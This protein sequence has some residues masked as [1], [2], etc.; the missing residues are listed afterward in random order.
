VP[1]VHRPLVVLRATDEE[2]GKA[3]TVVDEKPAEAA[4]AASNGSG[5]GAPAN[6]NG[7]GTAAPAT[8]AINPSD[9]E[10][11][12]SEPSGGDKFWTS[13]K[14]AFALPWRRFKKGSVLA[15]KLE[16]EISDQS[17]G[18]L[19]PGTSIP[20]LCEALHKAALDPRVTGLAIEVAPLALGY[21]K[22][23]EIRRYITLFRQSG[24]FTVAFMKQGGEKEY[25][26][27]SAC[28]E[29]YA[30]PT[31]SLS[32]RGF[33][34]GGTFL[35]GVLDKVGVEPQV[36]RIG[37][38]KSAGDQ[39]LRR[40]MAAEQREQLQCILDDTYADWVA[41]VAAARGKSEQEVRDLLDAGVYDTAQLAQGGWLDGL[42]YEDELI[43][44]LKQ[45][46]APGDKPEKPLRR[47]ALRKYQA[48]SPTAFG[49]RKGKKRV[50]VLRTA[51]AI[52][53]KA[54]SASSASITPDSLIPKLRA[55]A[56]DKSVA[57]V[58]LRVDSPGG[59]ALASDLMWR[60]VKKLAEKK[61]VIA[62]MA[63]VA[64][65]GGYYI[66]MAC[67]KIVAEPLTVTGSIGVVTGKFNLG[68]L[69]AKVGYTKE[70]ISRGRFAELLADNRAFNSEEARL[71]EEAARHAYESFRN[72]A[73]E[74][75]GMSVDAMQEVA[76]GRVWTGK[77]ALQIGLV[78]ALGGVHAA[79][80]LAKQA[81][82]L[83]ADEKV[84]VVEVGRARSSPLA[85]LQGGA[86]ASLLGAQA[87]GAPAASPAALLGL[88]LAPLLA[89]SPS[90]S[91]TA[92]S[93]VSAVLGAQ[94][95]TAVASSLGATAATAAA[96]A[97]SVG[98][99]S[100]PFGVT[101]AAE[102]ESIV[103]T[104]AGSAAAVTAAGVTAGAASSC[105]SFLDE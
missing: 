50:V 5:N 21:A 71:F 97:V 35:R 44:D 28:Q 96:E 9:L 54:T 89:A 66:A 20:Q 100:S 94:L 25:Y 3:V 92:S 48:V 7:N 32:L 76:Q 41:T 70:L 93:L 73:A 65:S 74:S 104:A 38:Y 105:D 2:S 68:E 11:T 39:L 58:V 64:A 75:R 27:A 37:A 42:K 85:L 29:I 46:T 13:F 82:G 103:V 16:G 87:S 59:D 62:S 23:Q 30:P 84:A 24:K 19:D 14:L 8:L 80:T 86:I 77:Q 34:V 43:D 1:V 101:L 57:A 10:L 79:V 15:I 55:L 6:G 51:G 61:P 67:S 99:L 26:L 81:A 22:L 69:Y 56:K 102:P 17:K 63:D 95:S 49:L 91:A 83:A 36:Q 4:E 90:A 47:V 33:A 40:T 78:D 98:A 12:W 18:W 60:E 31:A 88:V 52:L 72:K 45:R 53:G